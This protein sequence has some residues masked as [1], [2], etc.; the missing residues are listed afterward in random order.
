[1][2]VEKG[3]TDDVR[4][5]GA[6]QSTLTRQ[7]G[8]ALTTGK[9]GPNG[10]RIQKPIRLRIVDGIVVTAPSGPQISGSRST[11]KRLEEAPTTHLQ[12]FRK[13]DTKHLFDQSPALPVESPPLEPS[14]GIR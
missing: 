12:A 11:G 5:A 13:E 2:P 3:E 14:G 9:E 1:M 10:Q 8:I 4:E 7:N 6:Y